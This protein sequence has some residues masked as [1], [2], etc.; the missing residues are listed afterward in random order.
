MAILRGGTCDDSLN[1]WPLRPPCVA[2]P[3]D[4]HLIFPTFPLPRPNTCPRIQLLDHDPSLN[5][6]KT[7]LFLR[8]CHLSNSPLPTAHSHKHPHRN[9]GGLAQSRRATRLPRRANRLPRYILF[10][11]SQT[12]GSYVLHP[13]NIPTLNLDYTHETHSYP[14][15]STH[16]TNIPPSIQKKPLPWKHGSP[17]IS[18]ATSTSPSCILIHPR[19]PK[20]KPPQ[21]PNPS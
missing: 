3:F 9:N 8:H 13:R 12:Q 16:D 17:R 10:S 19:N 15:I 2:L 6:S 14:S 7:V 5:Y 4:T 1:T 21:S 11:L 20:R 18:N